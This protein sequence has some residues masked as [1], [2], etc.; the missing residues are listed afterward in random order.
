MSNYKVGCSPITS[1]IYVGAVS[2]T[3]L[4]GKKHNVTDTAV[5]AVAQNLLQTNEEFRF[6]YRGK[7]YALRVVELKSE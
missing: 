2:K 3:G 1:D 4:W 5:S 6:E 7:K